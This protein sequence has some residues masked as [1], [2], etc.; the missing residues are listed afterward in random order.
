[1]KYHA[2]DRVVG[3]VLDCKDFFGLMGFEVMIIGC[4]VVS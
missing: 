1:M 2:I 4:E 3:G